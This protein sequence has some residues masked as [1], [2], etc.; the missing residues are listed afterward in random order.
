MQG[1]EVRTLGASKALLFAK[2][3][4]PAILQRAHTSDKPIQQVLL[5]PAPQGQSLNPSH[6]WT[7]SS[8]GS[9]ANP[10]GREPATPDESGPPCQASQTI[11]DVQKPMPDTLP[12]DPQPSLNSWR[13]QLI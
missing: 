2:N 12:A 4:P 7:L 13:D 10:S 9:E 8:V 6:D 3:L 5:P 11:T 1:H